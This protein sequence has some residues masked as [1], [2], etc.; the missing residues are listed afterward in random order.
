VEDYQHVSISKIRKRAR[1]EVVLSA[2]AITSQ[3]TSGAQS[4]KQDDP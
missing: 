1:L 3:E 2:I 4:R